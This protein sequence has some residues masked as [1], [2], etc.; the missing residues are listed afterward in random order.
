VFLWWLLYSLSKLGTKEVKIT[1]TIKARTP[2]ESEAFL[3]GYQTAIQNI[4]KHGLEFAKDCHKLI[5]G[6]QE[7]KREYS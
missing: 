7:W 4:E 6:Y 5:S 3:Q 1:D 2:K